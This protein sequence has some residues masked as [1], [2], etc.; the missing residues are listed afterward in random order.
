MKR[1]LTI[2]AVITT[3][4]ACSPARTPTN[5]AAVSNDEFSRL[6][7]QVETEIRAAEKTGFLWRDTEQILRDARAAQRDGRRDEAVQLANKALRQA[8]QAQQ[9]ARDSANATPIY[10]KP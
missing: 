5:A 2:V 10:P 9:Q 6:A 7:A 3:L 1:F 4:G 8:Q